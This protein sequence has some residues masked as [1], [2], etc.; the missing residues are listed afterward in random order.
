MINPDDLLERI[1][2]GKDE[3][4]LVVI[5]IK[6]HKGDKQAR[7]YIRGLI[8]EALD[9]YTEDGYDYYYLMYIMERT[10]RIMAEKILRKHILAIAELE[11]I[12]T[13]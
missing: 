2:S 4:E 8:A 13:G 6:A 12:G 5:A 9:D 11:G 3:Q 1:Q 7:D 10:R